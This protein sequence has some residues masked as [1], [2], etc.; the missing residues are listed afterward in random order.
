MANVEASVDGAH[1]TFFEVDQSD[2]LVWKY[3]NPIVNSAP[4]AQGDNIS[5]TNN[6]WEN[7]TFRCTRYSPDYLGFNNVNLV[8]G[9]FIELN[10]LASNC[11]MLSAIAERPIINQE[12]SLLYIT[13]ILG[14]EITTKYNT[15]LFYI[16]DDGTVEKKFKIE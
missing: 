15:P 5:T 2:I 8:P 1:G 10:P 13:D 7:S 4:L 6:G 12:R 16:Y 14:R 9:D 3:I 11:Q